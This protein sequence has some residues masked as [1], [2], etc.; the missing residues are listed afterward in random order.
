VKEIGCKRK[1]KGGSKMNDKVKN[2]IESLKRN[3]FT[4]VYFNTAQE[5]KEKLLSEIGHD[6]TVGMGGS[7]TLTEMGIYDELQS[8][9]TPVYY[10]AKAKNPDEKEEFYEKAARADVYLSS[11]NA[12]TEDGLLINI[13][14]RGN[15]L[16]N[17]L[18][19]HKRLYIV[20]GTNKIARNYQDGMIR[21]KNIACPQNAERL[22]LN[23]PC[24]HMGKCDN[25]ISADRFCN[26][27][28]VMERQMTG[29]NTII[30]LINEK[31]G[32]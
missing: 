25:C 16:S 14:G 4:V 13:D 12:V 32:Y 26:A 28:L 15:R 29:A 23:T 5:A 3:G 2:T 6:E 30:Y 19:G 22:D 27:T 7:V 17:M 11:S 31:M 20:V 24:R 21:I 18:F 9:G 10:H 8:R 1:V